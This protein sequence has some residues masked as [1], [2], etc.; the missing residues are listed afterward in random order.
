MLQKIK[1]NQ[2]SII[3]LNR[4]KGCGSLKAYAR[5]LSLAFMRV[6]LTKIKR[7]DIIFTRNK[8]F[9]KC[10]QAGTQCCPS[11]LFGGE[12]VSIAVVC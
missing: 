1:Q 9:H 5:H 6:D 4:Q 3:L 8:K 2:K 10:N 12:S 7:Y 11:I